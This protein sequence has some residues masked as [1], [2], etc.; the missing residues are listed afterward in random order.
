MTA[1]ST[2]TPVIPPEV[3]LVRAF[4]N[5]VDVDEGT[6]E[7]DGPAALERWLRTHRVIAKGVAASGR[8]LA[9]ALR[10]RAALRDVLAANHDRRPAPAADAALEDVCRELPLTAVCSPEALAPATG[11]VRGALAKVVAASVTARIKGTWGR[12][13]ICPADDC[14]WAFYDTSRNRSRR[15]CSMEVCGNRQKVRTFRSR[16]H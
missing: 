1:T 9:L 7:L 6:D 14:A 13:K 15:W 5:T 4:V 10:L 2:E 8:D 3:E 16:A 11:G 12:L